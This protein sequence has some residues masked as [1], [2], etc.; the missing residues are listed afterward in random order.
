MESEKNHS[1][2]FQTSNDLLASS[3]APSQ[4][5]RVDTSVNRDN[6]P[7]LDLKTMWHPISSISEEWEIGNPRTYLD[8]VLARYER[9]IIKLKKQQNS[10]LVQSQSTP[11]C[12]ESIDA[13]SISV[14]NSSQLPIHPSIL[15]SNNL[16]SA[17]NHFGSA[18][19]SAAMHSQSIP[20]HAEAVQ[21]HAMPAHE[22]LISSVELHQTGATENGEELKTM[23]HQMSING[24]L[25][26]LGSPREYLDK[27]L[28]RSE[29]RAAKKNAVEQSSKSAGEQLQSMVHL[30]PIDGYL[31]LAPISNLVLDAQSSSPITE[32]QLTQEIEY[33]I[34]DVEPSVQAFQYPLLNSQFPMVDQVESSSEKLSFVH[35]T[36]LEESESSS[37][38]PDDAHQMLWKYNPVTWM[39]SPVQNESELIN[40]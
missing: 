8:K 39:L 17:V 2:M 30:T 11:L 13:H 5:N 35:L 3:D 27:V 15:H 38:F 23:W 32:H 24:K 4:L 1:K 14:V 16:S 6:S 28:A 26:P 40:P 36:V 25:L 34:S 18:A 20:Y 10:T 29:R 12:F 33:L 9:R 31:A 22:N 19:A 37:E 21:Q 7:R